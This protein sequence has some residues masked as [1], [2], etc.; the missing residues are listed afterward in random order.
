[1]NQEL[2]QFGSI[3]R[4]YLLFYNAQIYY[5]ATSLHHFQYHLSCLLAYSVFV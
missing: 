1:M 3:L 5:K 2:I 4:I